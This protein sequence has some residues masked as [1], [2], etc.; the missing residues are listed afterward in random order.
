MTVQ[1]ALPVFEGPL[2][3]LL[4]LIQENKID[5]YDIPVALITKQYLEYLELMKEIDLNIASEFLLMAATL[6]YIKSRMLL[7]R[8][9]PVEEDPR[10]ELVEKLIEYQKF[11]E[12]SQILK[13]RYKVWSMAFPRKTSGQEEFLL[14]ELSI[15]DLLTAFKKLLETSEP[16]IYIPRQYIKV[17]DKIEEIMNTLKIK[18]SVTFQE[19]FKPGAS[20][21]EII[22]TFLA[23][24]E[25]LKLGTIKAYQEKPFS[26]ILINLEE[27]NGNRDNF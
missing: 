3:L 18:K 2:D 8:Q 27:R 24:L 20:K 26:K 11:K 6:I 5:I 7:P 15:F 25:L 9:Q 10:Q 13:E 22:V 21:L 14:Q 12:A 19:L 4:H 17:E 23:L 16:K 1:I